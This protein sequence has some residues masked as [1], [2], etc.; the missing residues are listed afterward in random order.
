[1]VL[2]IIAANGIVSEDEFTNFIIQVSEYFFLVFWYP[3]LI[4][5]KL[6]FIDLWDISSVMF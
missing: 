3:V 1:M 5:L 2:L 4:S 6:S